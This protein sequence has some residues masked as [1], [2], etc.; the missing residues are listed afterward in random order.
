MRPDTVAFSLKVKPILPC[1]MWSRFW[2]KQWSLNY[3]SFSLLEA[4][5]GNRASYGIAKCLT[6]EVHIWGHAGFLSQFSNM[7]FFKALVDM[8]SIMTWCIM[9]TE[10]QSRTCQLIIFLHRFAMIF[11]HKVLHILQF[12][13]EVC[14]ILSRG[15]VLLQMS[16]QLILLWRTL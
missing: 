10:R 13:V 1:L 4:K 7:K 15:K 3:V 6:T 9:I 2:M 12:Q 14:E 16:L 8:G 5:C 11:W